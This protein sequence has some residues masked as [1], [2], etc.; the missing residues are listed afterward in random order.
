MGF[1]KDVVIRARA[2]LARRRADRESEN[3]ARLAEAYRKVPRIQE[4]D[5]LLRQTMAQAAQAVFTQGGDVAAAMEQAKKNNLALQA[6]RQ[7]LV[8]ANFPQGGLEEKPGCPHCADTGYVGSSM[9]DCLKALCVEQQRRALGDVFK[10]G[11]RFENFSLDHYSD[12]PIP[13]IRTSPRAVMQKN[14]NICRDYARYFA[15]NP[16]NLLLVGNTGLGK[17]H[18]ALAIGAAVGEQGYSVC[19][20]TAISLFGKLE[21]ARF[22]HTPESAE[23]AQKLESCD[24]LILDDLGTEMPGQFV[25][26]ALYGL[27]N[28]RLMG[29][30]SMV[31]TT[32]LNVEETGARYSPQIASRLY[33]EFTRLTFLGED[34]RRKNGG[35]SL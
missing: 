31:I 24:L 27:L 26:A 6:E 32:N 28:Q 30:K 3:A 13:R 11:E 4:I 12:T 14:L 10:G 17:T 18:L 35:A 5:R 34:I 29:G 16:G 33:G 1:S 19:Y 7:A 23:Q 8:Q 2:E 25:T 21:R 20:E 22:S 9:C 15:Q